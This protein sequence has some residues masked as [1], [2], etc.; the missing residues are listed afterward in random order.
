MSFSLPRFGVTRPVPVRL[1]MMAVLAGGVFAAFNIRREFFPETDPEGVRI[2]VPYPGATPEEIEESMARKIEDALADLEEVD[3]ITTTLAEGGGGIIVEFRSGVD[4]KEGMDEVERAIDSL[5][6]LPEDAE[7]IRVA[8]FEPKLPAIML[9][10][11]GRAPEEEMKRAIRRIA[12]DLRTLPGMGEVEV[13]GVRDYEVRVDVSEQALLEH[14]VSLPQVADA[15]QA[16][17][18]DVPGGASRTPTG[19]VNVRTLGVAERAAAIRDIVVRASPDGQALRVGDIAVVTDGFVDESLGR[20]FNGDPAVSITV[21]KTADQDAIDIAQMVRAYAAGRRGEPFEP[22]LVERAFH[23]SR[24][25]A[26]RL[27]ANHPDPLPGSLSTHSELAKYIEGRLDLLTENAIQGGVLI[28]LTIVIVMNLRIGWWVM[29]GLFTAICGTLLF[30]WA[31]DVTLNL[32]TMFG[33]LITLGMLEDDAIVVSEN[34]VARAQKGD[35]PVVAAISGAEQVFWPV[36]G[37]VLTTI[38]AFMPL[39]FVEGRIGDLLGALPWV[40]LFS[41][42]ASVLETMTILPSHMA[43]SLEKRM[44]KVP[45]RLARLGRRLEQWRDDV[46][47]QGLINLYARFMRLSMEYR[48]ISTAFALATLIGSFGLLAGGRLTFTFLPESD[49]ETI[50][51]DVRLPIG[52]A[53]ADTERIVARLEQ[54]AKEQPETKSISAVVGQSFNLDSGLSDGNATHLAQMYVELVPV[55][56][57]QERGQRQSFEV[58][59]GIRAAAG[60]IDEA[61][62]VRFSEISGGPG[63]ADLTIEVTGEDT[64]EVNDVVERIKARLR[65]F[66]GLHDVND[67]NFDGQREL[68]IR[69]KPGAASLGFTVADVA[70]QVRGVLFGL[71]PHVFSDRRE[72]IDVR[73]RLDESSRHDLG[74]IERLWIISPAGHAVPLIEVADLIDG[75]GYAVIRRID[76]QRAVTVTADAAAGVNPEEVTAEVLPFLDQLRLEHPRVGIDLAGRQRDLADAFATLPIA[77]A[78]ASL[79]IYVIL[80]WLFSSYTQPFVVMLAIPFSLIGVIWGH[81]LLGYQATFLSLIGFVALTGVVVNNSLILIEFFNHRVRAG[82]PLREALVEAGRDRLRPIVLTSVTTFCGLSPLIFETSFQAK[83]LIPMAISISFGLLSATVLTLGVL[84]CLIVILDDIKAASHYLWHGRPRPAAT[85]HAAAR[86]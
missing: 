22:T 61:E 18:T 32:L 83:F 65:E 52:S 42:L 55:E 81:W 28:L 46:I 16:W 38:V 74:S 59:E 68:Q 10:L 60:A 6:D 57:R 67:D 85:P 31:A 12:D 84:P 49:S 69:L 73:V 76:R 9:T 82:M 30:M 64:A 51:V 26:W 36:I 48:Y 40:V 71:D 4:I 43:H 7:E 45:G 20:R 17:M 27:G 41:L 62:S 39:M 72:D 34:I 24:E 78:A 80:A 15:I 50:V 29:S 44:T 63:G 11:H 58:I 75:R 77:F 8:E 79:M 19:N 1:M 25:Q 37:T 47:I 70:R 13:S 53:L 56:T 14:G 2:T 33:L 86:A 5:T 66:E 21:F 35:P 3:E 54:A 23:S